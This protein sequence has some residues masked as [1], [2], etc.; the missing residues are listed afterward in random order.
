MLGRYQKLLCC[1]I[2]TLN[3]K[4]F[5]KNLEESFWINPKTINLISISFCGSKQYAD[6]LYSICSFYKNVGQPKQWLIYSDGTLTTH[7]INILQKI[8]NVLVKQLYELNNYFPGKLLK[9]FPTLNKV[10]IVANYSNSADVIMY[11][12]SDIVFYQSFSKLLPTDT[13]FNYYL[14]DEAP[15]YFDK[16]FLKSNSYIEYPFNFGLLIQKKPLNIEKVLDYIRQQISKN[17]L[18]YWTDQTGFQILIQQSNEFLPLDKNLF[19]VGG[20]DSF[21]IAHCVDYKKIA[22]RHFVGPVRHKMW[23]YHWKKVLGL[24]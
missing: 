20:K 15:Y 14:V 12:D 1:Y 9:Q 3:K 8:Q 19:K 21:T 13:D 17:S 10:N 7:Q 22:L 6:Q 2:S 4:S 23:Q 24:K 11:T 5:L 16:S 18:K